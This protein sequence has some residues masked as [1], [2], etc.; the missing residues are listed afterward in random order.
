MLIN[1]ANDNDTF[2]EVYENT[3]ATTASVPTAN[4]LGIDELLESVRSSCFH[5]SLPS[6]FALMY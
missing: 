1:M 3:E 4:L 6:F 2:G 5:L